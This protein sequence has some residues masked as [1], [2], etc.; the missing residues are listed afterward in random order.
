L[1]Q[2]RNVGR[3]S[4][5]IVCASQGPTTGT[6]FK[7]GAVGSTAGSRAEK[8]DSGASTVESHGRRACSATIRPACVIGCVTTRSAPSAAARSCSYVSRSFG[9]SSSLTMTSLPLS[10]SMTRS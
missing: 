4:F 9:I 1:T 8:N 6:S 3:A 2:R 10:G 7:R 5:K